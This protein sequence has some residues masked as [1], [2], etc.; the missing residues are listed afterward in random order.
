MNI[1]TA[2]GAWCEIYRERIKNNIRLAL[3]LVPAG[4]QFCAVLKADAYGHGIDIVAPLV[5]AQGIRFI[6]ITTNDEAAAVRNVGF[7][8]ALLRLRAATPEEME[9]AALLGIEEQVSSVAAAQKLKSL[10]DVGVAVRAHLPLNAHGMS[11]EGLEVSEV[12]GREVCRE[13]LELLGDSIVGICSHFPSN[14]PDDLRQ[15]SHIFQQ[16]V[17]WVLDN[18]TL[19]RSK[20]LIH[21]GSSL[22]LISDEVIASDMYRCGAILYGILKPELGFMTTMSL[23]SRVVNVGRYPKGAS[24]G[25]DRALRLDSERRL[26]SVSVGYA[27]G[28]RRSFFPGGKV[29]VGETPALV[30]G[31]ISMNTLVV[32]VTQIN[33]VNVGDEVKLFDGEC[34]DIS[35]FGEAEV[36]FGTILADLFTDWGMRNQKMLL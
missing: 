17:A 35:M 29:L 28:I 15:S 33:A 10:R 27:N 6:G 30:V 26:A 19:Q 2:M 16:Q 20:L 13:I 12:G 34:C 11:R 25:Y 4:S 32:D 23:K 5:I 24:V 36:Q 14:Q 21:A 7:D 1:Q 3:D 18:S 31:K 22:T 9:A 8:G